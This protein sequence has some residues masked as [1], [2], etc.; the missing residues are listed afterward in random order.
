MSCHDQVVALYAALWD[1]KTEFERNKR[2]DQ[3][4]KQHENGV[5]PKRCQSDLAEIAAL[6]AKPKTTQITQ[7]TTKTTFNPPYTSGQ[8]V[9][10]LINDRVV[11]KEEY[12]RAKKG[13]TL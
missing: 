11:T 12:D 7:T 13:G 9:A 3:I 10:Y 5:I 4:L 1:R 2:R 6:T 8:T